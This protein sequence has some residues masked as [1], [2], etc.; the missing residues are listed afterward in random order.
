M[1]KPK[2]FNIFFLFLLIG[3]ISVRI[4]PA[5]DFS[6]PG[7]FNTEADY[8]RIRQKIA[9]K[10]E[11]WYTAW[12]NLLV[13]PEAQLN[14]TSHATETVIRG[15]T[16]DNIVLMYR[17]VASIYE[18]AL[19][20]KISGDVSHANKAVELLNSWA[21]INKSVSGNADRY[22]AAG[23]NG[24]QFANAAEM[25]RGYP[26]FEFEKFKNYMLNVFYF[27]MNERFL[28]GNEYGSAHNDA[29]ATNYRVNWD[30]CNMNAMMAISILCD[31]KDGFNKA[32]N[33]AKNG[34]GTGNIKR[35]VNFIHSPI[36]GQWEESG[37][38]QGHAV[39]GLM[40]YGVFCEMAWNQGVDMYSYDD[41]RYRK[42]AEYVARYNIMTDSA[43]TTLGK[44]NDLPYTS[45]SRQMG[46]TCTWY[47]ESVLGSATRGKYGN[48]WEM[49]YNHYARR[50][51]Q[52][53]KVKSIYEILQQ[54][55]ST[56]VPSTTIHADTYDQPA[57]I[58]LTH[59]VDSNSTV[60][61]WI[62]MDVSP[63]ILT[64]YQYYG[65]SVL[66]DSAMTVIGSGTGMDAT[67]DFCQ[68]TFQKITDNGTI[69]ARLDSVNDN[70]IF[71]QAGLMMRDSLEQQSK[72]VFLNFSKSTGVSL[73][74]RDSVSTN[75]QIIANDATY[76]TLPLWIKINRSGNNFVAS[77]SKNKTDWIV[78]GNA[79]VKMSRL[80]Y[81]GMT[82]SSKKVSE[83]CMAKFDK[84]K[85]IQ[86]NIYPIIKISNPIHNKSLYVTPANINIKGTAYDLDGTMEKTEIYIND[87]LWFLSKVSPLN[88]KSTIT[89]TGVYKLIA[90]AYDNENA[91]QKTDTIVFAV[92]TP[93]NKLPYYK[94][95]ETKIGYF[96]YD[97]SGNNLNGI[98]YNGAIPISGKINNG[99]A[100]DGVS[101]YVK[102]PAGFIEKLSNFTIS[103][104]V[105]LNAQTS[106]A[107][108]FDFGSGTNSYMY[109]TPY[110]G[111]GLI[112]FKIQTSD[113]RYQ[114]VDANRAFPT[115]AWHHIAITLDTDNVLTIYLDGEIIGKGYSFLLR[116]YDI[117][118]TSTNYIGKSQFTTDSY[119]NA[120]LDEFKFYNYALTQVEINSL[121]SFT[122]VKQ[123]Y[124]NSIKIFPNPA[125]NT[126]TIYND[127]DIEKAEI[128]D[129]NG[130]T[131]KNSV[132]NI[133]IVSINE[134][135]NGVY[136]IKIKTKANKYYVEK[137]MIKK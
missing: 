82:A 47:T 38:D 91:M 110:S 1:K 39:G 118:P 65:N 137:F 71:C 7:I 67:K 46:S 20:Y 76:N 28:I 105:Y 63:K 14:W 43:G 32:I 126:L 115:G 60:L 79:N 19:I 3:S 51:N 52:G 70:S 133:K 88:F 99:L 21:T 57:V 95:D 53:E 104:W 84:A 41:C 61:P 103:G 129:V 8:A 106:W 98:L 74:V 136:Q 72:V 49:I 9:E 119:L 24:Y 54:Q 112:S 64:K 109:L 15:G 66:T 58:T 30:A 101:R 102:L 85:I 120:L 130:K 16:G 122:P 83:K 27:P 34:D 86:G 42:G 13:A 33:Y 37:R 121:I 11:P 97:A 26:G 6:H 134:L 81:A 44:Y 131:V 12:N 40:L 17:D 10:Q 35:T 125:K 78:I 128:I 50:L 94:F 56:R 90:K 123:I 5:Q 96:A 4:L 117:N 75:I 80:C 93:S 69:I 108:I 114:V 48:V 100:L 23:L 36:W 59:C 127:E 132:G 73:L 68:Y 116:P 25:M 29:C 111:S 31:Y 2:L 55:P 77:V 89:K 18:H 124:G 107:R 87:S 45:Y 22:L 92:N 113:G 135:E 62:N